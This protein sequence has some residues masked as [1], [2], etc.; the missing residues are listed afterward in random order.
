MPSPDPPW[1]ALTPFLATVDVK[2]K[3]C[4]FNVGGREVFNAVFK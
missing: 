3:L 2:F 4:D 1:E